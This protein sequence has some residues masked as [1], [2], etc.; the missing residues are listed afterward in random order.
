VHE[1]QFCAGK[2]GRAHAVG[3]MVP[4]QRERPLPSC[5]QQPVQVAGSHSQWSLVPPSATQVSPIPHCRSSPQAQLRVV[6]WHWFDFV[7]SQLSHATAVALA[8]QLGY[9]EFGVAPEEAQLSP[10]QQVLQLIEQPWHRPVPGLLQTPLMQT[11]QVPENPH[12]I[13]VITPEH[14]PVASQQP[15]Q[16]EAPL[17]THLPF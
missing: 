14:L 11:S 8:A 2:P 17:Q 15:L 13:L 3:P 1:K 7:T 12:A 5:S 16:P 4:M 10:I 9:A 6:G